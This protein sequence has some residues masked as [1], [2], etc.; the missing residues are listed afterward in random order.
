MSPR[1]SDPAGSRVPVSD[2]PHGVDAPIEE[3]C[4]Q[5]QDK[6]DNVND[7]QQHKSLACSSPKADTVIYGQ[8]PFETLQHKVPALAAK[9]FQRSPK[10]ITVTEM[11]G[12]S[13]NRV[14]G[15]S[16]MSK[17]RKFSLAWFLLSCLGRRKKKGAARLEKYVLRIPRMGY[18]YE[19]SAKDMADDMERDVAVLKAVGSRMPLPIPK[20]ASYDLT[21]EN[22]FERPYMVQ[23]H[24]P[25][26]TLATNIWDDLNIEQKKHLAKEITALAPTIASVEGPVGDISTQNLNRPSNSPIC[27]QDFRQ[28]SREGQ[29]PEP[30][31]TCDAFDWMWERCRQW[32]V[33]DTTDDGYVCF[34][35]IWKSFANIVRALDDRGFLDGP[36]VLVHGDLKIYNILAEV[37]SDTEAVITGVIDW[38]TAIIA[39]EFM[40]YRAPFWLWTPADMASADEDDES[41]A[42]VELATD[43]DRI[44]KQVFL[45]NASDKYKFFAFAPE[46]ML[47]RRM[48]YF[49]QKGMPGSWNYDEAK[50]VVKEWDKLHPE[51][52]VRFRL[53]WRSDSEAESDSDDEPTKDDKTTKEDKPCKDIESTTD[54]EEDE[55]IVTE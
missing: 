52:N 16:F 32:S 39:P 42:N 14:V 45:D 31:T 15:V 27:T 28:P 17:P 40:A 23:G 29:K 44:L 55:P 26:R 47:A 11:K 20:V 21:N 53:D 25:G 50:A 30:A 46:A 5:H 54:A 9:L 19:D 10:D 12:G 4:A 34:D 35:D 13:F 1:S 33:H 49:L 51:D 36:C 6:Q 48:F 41:V 3:T 7:E 18:E 24:L 38:D 37:R 43:E 8:E 22:I 2:A